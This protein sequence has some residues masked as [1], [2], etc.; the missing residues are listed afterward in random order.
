MNSTPNASF[1][2]SFCLRTSL[3]LA[4]FVWQARGLGELELSGG[5]PSP[6]GRGVPASFGASH[7]DKPC[8]FL[9]RLMHNG[10]ALWI[11]FFRKSFCA[12]CHEMNYEWQ[13]AAHDLRTAAHV[14]LAEVDML[15]CS[16]IARAF[17]VRFAPTLVLAYGDEQFEHSDGRTAHGI[18]SACHLALSRWQVKATHSDPAV[19]IIT[20]TAPLLDVALIS[21]NL[22]WL[23]QV[24]ARWPPSPSLLD[25]RLPAL[26]VQA[27]YVPWQ[28]AKVTSMLGTK[29]KG[30]YLYPP[31]PNNNKVYQSLQ[32]TAPSLEAEVV[33]GPS[34]SKACSE[35]VVEVSRLNYRAGPNLNSAVLGNWKA[36]QSFLGACSA[37]SEDEHN[38]QWLATCDSNITSRFAAPLF[39]TRT[40]DDGSIRIRAAAGR[41]QD[42]LSFI[43]VLP[44][45]P[46]GDQILEQVK[47]VLV[48]RTSAT[49]EYD[50]S[51]SQRS[52]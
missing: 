46:V 4:C 44:T 9:P 12:H 36:G 10:G 7:G 13:L 18:L 17:A 38:C 31:R 28:D 34:I 32:I 52:A 51:N 29:R 37:E 47:Q 33:A 27:A 26:G 48:E 25:P 8:E 1:W 6:V 2:T 45:L 23:I 30:F 49:S 35:W 15:S 41:R 43:H 50:H 24:S 20:L 19:P 21:N 5:A 22:P 39:L 42:L 16:T 40:G 14:R 11:I 3:F